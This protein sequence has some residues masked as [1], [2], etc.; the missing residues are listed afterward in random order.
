MLRNI[1]LADNA[2]AYRVIN[3]MVDVGNAVGKVDNAAFRRT[4]LAPAGMAD[5][6]V[7]KCQLRTL[8]RKNGKPRADSPRTRETLRVSLFPS[9]PERMAAQSRL[10]RIRQRPFRARAPEPPERL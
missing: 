10:E 3:I 9:N 7:F 6:R 8:V 1:V 2:R 4:R 5:L